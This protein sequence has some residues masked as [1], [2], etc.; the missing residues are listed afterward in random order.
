MVELLRENK[1]EI[2]TTQVTLIFK[3][4]PATRLSV[5]TRHRPRPVSGLKNVFKGF[6]MFAVALSDITISNEE[7]SNNISQEQ[8]CT[9]FEFA[10]FISYPSY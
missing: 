10:T 3:M 9:Q 2:E 4:Q 8:Q 7:I 6:G 5:T 1:V